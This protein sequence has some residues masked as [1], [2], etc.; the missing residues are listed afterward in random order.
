MV[1]TSKKCVIMKIFIL[2][3]LN[4]LNIH[5]LLFGI[6]RISKKKKTK[7]KNR[8]ISKNKSVKINQQK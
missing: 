3:H 8:N 2:E 7:T 5:L 4:N 1:K 6:H